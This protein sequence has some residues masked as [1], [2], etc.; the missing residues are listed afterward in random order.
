MGL[1]GVS[2]RKVMAVALMI[3][4]SAIAVLGQKPL[5]DWNT[6]ELK[7]LTFRYS[8]L[9]QTEYLAYTGVALCSLVGLARIPT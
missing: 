8:I 4:A 5:S 1:L 7:L 2:M 3:S 9:S 6:G